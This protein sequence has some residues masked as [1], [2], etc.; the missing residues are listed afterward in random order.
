[1]NVLTELGLIAEQ[2][3]ASQA[4][5]ANVFGPE[6]AWQVVKTCLETYVRAR[7]RVLRKEIP[8]TQ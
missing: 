3:E 1:M 8:W 4:Q 7:D 5:I 2:L 6:I